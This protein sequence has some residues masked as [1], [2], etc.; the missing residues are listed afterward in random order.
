MRGQW[1]GNFTGTSTGYIITNIDET[2]DRFLGRAVLH[3]NPPL[4]PPPAPLPITVGS[5]RTANKNQSGSFLADVTH[6]DPQTQSSL[7]SQQLGATYPGYTFPNTATVTYSFTPAQLQIA[8]STNIGTTGQATLPAS[9]AAA[10]S[11]YVAQKMT[12]LQFKQHVDT[13]P[14]RKRIFRGQDGPYRLRTAYHRRGRADLQRYAD[15]DMVELYGA[16]AARTRHHY[17]VSVP[18][19]NAAFLHLAQHHGYPTPLLDWSYSPYVAA[20]CA[21]RTVPAQSGPG[22][23][24]RI[25][26]FDHLTW[27]ADFEQIHFLSTPKLHISVIEAV[28]FDNDR[29]R[30]QQALSLVTN[31]DD[32]EA[33]IRNRESANGKSYISMIDIACSER[34]AVM[35]DLSRMGISAGSMFPGLD[36]ACEELRERLFFSA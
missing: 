1:L 18:A 28:S 35:R 2:E 13:L 21:F 12:W 16:L 5:F 8:W 33:H 4:A 29:S 31:V 7:T 27:Q 14:Y 23:F 25:V 11:S 34:A 26:I 30:P 19:E 22:A 3:F 15:Q 20:F 10:P 24:A 17:N 6:F 36:G 9:Q 32:V